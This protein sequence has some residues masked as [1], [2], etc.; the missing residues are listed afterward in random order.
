MN[1]ATGL[2]VFM[3]LTISFTMLAAS[4]ARPD[5]PERVSF[6]HVFGTFA[7]CFFVA[8]GVAMFFESHVVAPLEARIAALESQP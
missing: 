2:I 4:S 6:L 3:G 8:I 5:D 1:D 7:A